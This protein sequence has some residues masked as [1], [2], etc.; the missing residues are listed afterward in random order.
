MT[1]GQTR[2]ALLG[3]AATLALAGCAATP[4][5]LEV[6]D[7]ADVVPLDEFSE[8]PRD[9]LWSADRLLGLPVRGTDGEEIGEVGNLVVG[10]DDRLRA[11]IV[12]VGGFLDIGDTHLRVPWN[13]VGIDPSTELEY[14]ELPIPSDDYE[15]Y[16]A[17]GTRPDDGE[18]REW[19]VDELLG[20]YASLDGETT[21]DYG[22]VRDVVFDADGTLES[23][24][25][26]RSSR[27]GGGYYNYPYRGYRYGFDPGL[28]T[29]GIGYGASDIGGYGAFSGYGAFGRTGTFGGP[30]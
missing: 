20:D 28:N 27:Y 6:V 13:E 9:G 17:A 1:T 11:M 15:R 16:D 19:R 24:V 4:E 8:R 2:P 22:V 26:S 10:P 18:R 14:A 29:Y 3:L 12:E 30:L 25:V 7:D 21:G 23:V 5:P